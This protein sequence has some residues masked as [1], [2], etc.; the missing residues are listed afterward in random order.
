MS[1]LLSDG[2]FKVSWL[3]SVVNVHAPTVAELNAGTSLE[4]FITPD[5]Y[6]NKASTAP[7]ATSSL[8]STF[9][10]EAS[11]RRKFD[12]SLELMRQALPDPVYALLAYKTTGFLAVRRILPNTTAWASTQQVGVFPVQCGQR[13]END[14]AP[15]E[16]QKYVVPMFLTADPDDNAVVA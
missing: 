13:E 6:K 8:A 15:N 4:G 11:G 1:N 5:G 10:T 7:I 3:P 9:D 2:N 14:A 16:V 12:I